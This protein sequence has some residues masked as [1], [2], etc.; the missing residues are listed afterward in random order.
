MSEQLRWEPAEG[1][2]AVE[3]PAGTVIAEPAGA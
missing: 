2:V 1:P 3:V